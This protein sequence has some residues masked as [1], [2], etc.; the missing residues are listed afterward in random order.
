MTVESVA[1]RS[2]NFPVSKTVDLSPEESFELSRE[3]KFERAKEELS[4]MFKADLSEVLIN[5]S[6]ILYSKKEGFD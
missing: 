4:K 2:L 5:Y 3:Y 1:C 6:E